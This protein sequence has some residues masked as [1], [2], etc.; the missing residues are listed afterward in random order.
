MRSSAVLL[1][2]VLL[3]ALSA[4]SSEHDATRDTP[5]ALAD[6]ADVDTTQ[7]ARRTEAP[8]PPSRS[9]R[10]SEPTAPAFTERAT[11]PSG[12]RDV[13]AERARIIEDAAAEDRPSG[14]TEA[15]IEPDGTTYKPGVGVIPKYSVR[16]IDRKE[17]PL[18]PDSSVM[19]FVPGSNVELP[20]PPAKPPERIAGEEKPT[21]PILVP[22]E[23]K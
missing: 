22:R 23:V 19:K 10:N 21:E 20:A 14:T 2:L 7:P 3:G 5:A 6:T 18:T 16:T 4:C 15:R 1:S 17:P 8:T 11:P 13:H 12:P 9:A